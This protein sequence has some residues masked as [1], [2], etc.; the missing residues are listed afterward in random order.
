M[1]A[2]PSA[3]TG[4]PFVKANNERKLKRWKAQA[5]SIAG[6]A[7]R[8]RMIPKTE[9]L[10]V[11]I[12]FYRARN[13]T[14]FGTGRNAELLKASAPP[15]PITAPDIDKLTRSVLDAMTG[16][17][18]ANDSQVVALQVRKLYAASAAEER[19]EVAVRRQEIE[20]AG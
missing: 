13:K 3:T 18:Y 1:K 9:P 5:A 2:I 12:D 16:V 11:G 15:Y 6:A 19:T 7:Y 14:H 20:E 4:R 17:I 8:T 10:I